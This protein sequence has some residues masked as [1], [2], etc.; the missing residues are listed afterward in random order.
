MAAFKAVLADEHILFLEGIKKIL[1]EIDQPRIEV[2]ATVTTGKDLLEFIEREEADLL[3]FEVNFTDINYGELIRRI[4][5]TKKTVK[6]F[7]LS[8]YG[9]I[10]LVKS[11]F[12]FGVDG[13]AIKSN[14]KENLQQGLLDVLQDKVFMGEGLFVSPQNNS[15]AEEKVKSTSVVHDRFLLRQKL[16]KRELEILELII[17]GQNNRQIAK[18]LFISDQTVGVHRKNIMKKLD[19]NSTPALIRFA[20]ENKIV[21]AS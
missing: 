16:T 13:F 8:A 4:K 9:D 6:L 1:H 3:L 17:S 2:I 14:S 19:V 10:K 12:E 11:C 15:I 18:D 20:I 21:N 7:V 5:K